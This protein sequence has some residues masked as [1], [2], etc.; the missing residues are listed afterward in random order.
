MCRKS[1]RATIFLAF[2]AAM[3]PDW[4]LRAGVRM[5]KLLSVL[6][7]L[8]VCLL[9]LKIH[10]IRCIS[11][12][13][14][15]LL[16]I[17]LPR[18]RTKSFFPKQPPFRAKARLAFIQRTCSCHSFQSLIIILIQSPQEF[19]TAMPNPLRRGNDTKFAEILRL[20]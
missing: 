12:A 10:R 20:G 5:S 2:I 11:S 13:T 4:L 6:A 18:N 9:F 1:S 16:R 15:D 8:L 7:C 19:R 3:N 17:N 14:P